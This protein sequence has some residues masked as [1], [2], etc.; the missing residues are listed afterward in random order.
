MAERLVPEHVEAGHHT[1][2][3]DQERRQRHAADV[4]AGK[5]VPGDLERVA[6]DAPGSAAAPSEPMAPA[7]DPST[8]DSTGSIFAMVRVLAPSVLKTAA[9]Y[10]R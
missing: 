2:G 7:S 4:L 1:D 8:P 6:A 3:G 9:S 5:D 10:T